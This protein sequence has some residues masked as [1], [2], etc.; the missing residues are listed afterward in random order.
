MDVLNSRWQI[1]TPIRKTLIDIQDS[2]SFERLEP[3]KQAS[4]WKSFA[5]EERVLL[6]RLLVLQGAQQLAKGDHQVLESFEIASQ[7]SSNASEILYQQGSI[8]STYR[9]NIRCLTLACQTLAHALQQDPTICKG[10]YLRAQVLSDIGLFEGDASYFVEAHQNFERAHVLL[11]V[12]LETIARE[13]FYWKWGFCLASLGKVSGEPLDF[14]HSIEK[15]RLAYEL[16]CQQA[17]FFNDFGHSF[18]DLA[19]LLEKPE[20]FTEALKLFNQAVRQDSNAFEG[21][22][23][24]ACC[25]QSLVECGHH[26]KLLE[27]AE[28]SFVKAAEINP[29]SSQLWLKWGQLETTIGKVKHDQQKLEDSLAKFAKA[30]E[31]EPGHPQILSSWAETELFLGAQD[32]RLDLLQSARAKIL[33]SLEVQP[34]D[35]DVWYLYG[36]CLNEL[37]RYFNDED[38]YNQAIEKF[39]YGLSLTRHHPLLWYGLA[40]AHFAL[41]ELTDQQALFEKAVRYCSRVIECGGGGFAQF[42]NDWGVALMK[43]A[44][45]TQQSTHVEMAIEKFERALK[46]PIQNIESEDVDLEWVYNYGSAFDLLGDL[47]DEP[48]HFEKA[49]HILTQVLQLDPHY[50]QARYN[51]AL[52]LSHLGEAMFDVELYHK[53]IEHFQYLLDLDP[54]DEMIHLDFGMCLT[55]L[56]LLVHDVHHP[57]RSQALYRQAESH[58]MQAVALGNAQ[59]YYQLAGLYSITGHYDHAMHYLERAQFFG[60]L[61]GIEDLLHDEWLEDLRE[62]PAFRQFINELSSQQSMDDK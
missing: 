18:A 30:H 46:Q 26:E 19:S 33:N 61:P 50:N 4:V 42:W 28:R 10:W 37:G 41:G 57:E 13:E 62:I 21:W 11:D 2:Q 9:D 55:N 17:H 7:I 23:N 38:Y 56:A 40:L 53:A 1:M 5:Q 60:T 32:E 22:Y 52:A 54:E 15:Y 51:L 45:T 49:V 58:L 25:M 12:S 34:E 27:Q 6:A 8:L 31:L 35:S 24:Q 16:G 48:G 43:L 39:Q 29:Q 20:Y 59:S 36:S 14:L 3:F 47:T 44:E